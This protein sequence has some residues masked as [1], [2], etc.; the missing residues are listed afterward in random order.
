VRTELTLAM[1]DHDDTTINIALVV[2]VIIFYYIAFIR[3][4]LSTH[5]QYLNCCQKYCKA[6]S[7]QAQNS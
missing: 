7:K 6:L 2:I 3:R 4:G 1:A 5:I